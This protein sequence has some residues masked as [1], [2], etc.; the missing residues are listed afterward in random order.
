V[1][2]G[3][4]VIAFGV[5]AAAGCGSSEPLSE[6]AR[7]CLAKLG[8]Y[9]HHTPRPVRPTNTVPALPVVDPDFKP[10]LGRGRQGLA[11]PKEELD[12]YGEIS[13]GSPKQGANA[14]QIL[15]FKH[16]DLPKR[17]MT[18]TARLLRLQ[19]QGGQNAFFFLGTA[20]RPVR[21]DRTLVLWSSKP[22]ASQ[23]RAVYGCL[24]S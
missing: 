3:L 22:S 5:V 7:P 20:P 8:R 16:D 24:E 4:V 17:V 11:W 23:T 12:E 14:V 9:V 10:E 1:R 13:Y 18:A 2:V 21:R 19:Q 15:I 6:T